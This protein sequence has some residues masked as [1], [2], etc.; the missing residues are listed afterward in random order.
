MTNKGDAP[1]S[2]ADDDD[3]DFLDDSPDGLLRFE[4]SPDDQ[5]IKTITNIQFRD[6]K[7]FKVTKRVRI[8]KQICRV[9]KRSEER[10]KIWKKFG[11]AVNNDPSITVVDVNP[12][13][14]DV[15]GKLKKSGVEKSIE[16]DIERMM[17][18]SQT[19]SDGAFQARSARDG[20]KPTGT[21]SPS[22]DDKAKPS[23]EKTYRPPSQRDG[24][25]DT[26][27]RTMSSR[28]SDNAFTVRVTNLSDDITETD[29]RDLFGKFGRLQRVFLAKDRTTHESKGFAF[30]NFERQED[31]EQAIAKV[32][33]IGYNHLILQVEWARK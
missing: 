13:P 18:P 17:M 6:G 4:S 25:K 33:G 15:T 14:F 21:T 23:N 22:V 24:G 8:V 20:R 5:G 9:N 2:W 1:T 11:K 26:G 30:I 32:S 10:L 16:K 28:D 29:L 7:K 27:G 3:G 12:T 19:K 31:A